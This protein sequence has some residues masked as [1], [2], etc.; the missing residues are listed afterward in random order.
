MFDR[1]R[2]VSTV[3][4]VKVDVIDSQ[5]R[6]GLVEGLPDVLWVT[7]HDPTWFSMAETKLGGKEDLIAFSGPFEPMLPN[8]GQGM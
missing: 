6:Q 7:P 3:E 8:R 1:D 2:W 5:P 4:V